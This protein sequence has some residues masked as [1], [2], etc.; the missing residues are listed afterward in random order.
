MA[1]SSL[2]WCRRRS[3]CVH[4]TSRSHTLL[5]TPHRCV[6][7]RRWRDASGARSRGAKW[8]YEIG[9]DAAAGGAAAGAGGSTSGGGLLSESRAN[10]VFLKRDTPQA[11]V[12]RIRNLPYPKS[13][14]KLAIDGDKQ[15]VVL[16]TTNKKYYKRIDVPAMRR[17]GLALDARALGLRYSNNTLVISYAKPP[18]VVATEAEDRKSKL[19]AASKGGAGGMDCQ[20]Q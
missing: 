20:T 3:P 4:A 19:D 11:W 9:D 12:W 7:V 18:P 10:P 16:S 2:V 14:Y 6:T 8:E 17:A 5:C 15:Q 1:S 13:T